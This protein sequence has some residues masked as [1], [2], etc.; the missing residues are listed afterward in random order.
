MLN[1]NNKFTLQRNNQMFELT[2]SP[3]VNNKFFG[4]NRFGTLNNNNQLQCQYVDLN[5]QLPNPPILPPPSMA[6]TAYLVQT[7]NGSALLIPP[8]TALN[9]TN[10]FIQTNSSS[11]QQQ[12][13]NTFSLNRNPYGITTIPIQ[14]NTLTNT[15]TTTTTLPNSISINNPNCFNR[16]DSTASTNVYQ[17]IDTEKNGYLYPLENF[18]DSSSFNNNTVSTNTNNFSTRHKQKRIFQ[19]QPHQQFQHLNHQQQQFAK[20]MENQQNTNGTLHSNTNNTNSNYFVSPALSATSNRRLSN[21]SF[22]ERFKYRVSKKLKQ[23]CSWKCLAMLFLFI[24]LNLFT[25]TIYLAV[26]RMYNLNWHLKEISSPSQTNLITSKHQSE[27]NRLNQILFY[28]I[29]DSLEDQ[30]LPYEPF[31]LQFQIYGTKHVKFNLTINK[32]SHIGI[33]IDK[34]TPP[35]FTK[36]KYF[37]TFDGNTL[38]SKNTDRKI[39]QQTASMVNTGFVHY[40]E[41]GLWYINLLNDNKNTLR[42]RLKTEYYEQTDSNCPMSCHGKGECK[43]GICKCFTGF[44][45]LDCSE[46]VCPVLCSDHGKYDNG[47]CYCDFNWH[48]AECEIPIDQCEVPNCNGNGE[49]IKGKCICSPGYQGESCNQLGCLSTNCS[50][51]GVCINSKC[52]CF[53]NYTGSDCSQSQPSISNICS[54]HGDF[55]YGTKSCTCYKGYSG[56]DCSRNDNCVDKLCSICKNGWNGPNCLN[57]VPFQCDIRCSEHGICVNGTC[58]CSPGYQGRNCDISNDFKI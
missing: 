45:G 52:I 39:T 44:T 37:E 34:N 32:N 47:K 36:F 26:M 23:Y 28:N 25:F 29:G 58:N 56:A 22:L 33:Y 50:N 17:T 24:T 6:T 57:K 48:G 41:E 1:N 16:P 46:N 54:N 51:N 31:Y 53:S 13:Q 12:Q 19:Q 4:T 27:Q 5:G 7:P 40:L 30:I 3:K 21:G 2:Q 20:L 15:T 10:H 35:T 43:N 55:D 42:F 38:I 49:C 18:Y 11:L 9:P 14:N 8:Q